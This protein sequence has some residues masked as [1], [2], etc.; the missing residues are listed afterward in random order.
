MAY[1]GKFQ[2]LVSFVAPWFLRQKNLGT[3]LEAVGLLHDGAAD[4]MIQGMRL[5][6]P[7]RCPANQLPTISYDRGI[8]LYPSEPEASQRQRLSMWWQLHKTRGSHQGEM[9]HVQPYFLPGTLPWIRIVHQA[10]DG[11]VATWHTLDPS[12]HYSAT[13]ASPSNWNWDG[14]TSKWSRWWAIVYLPAGYASV[15]TGTWD[16]SSAWDG[17]AL[18]DGL[19]AAIFADLWQMFSDWKAARSWFGGLIV[20]ALQPTDSI[21]GHPGVHPFD[22]ASTSTTNADG[23]TNLP[24]GS[25]GSPVYLSGPSLGLPTRP[26]W[27]TFYNINNG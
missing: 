14:Q 13:T 4:N 1:F 16:G 23:S 7:L 10:G 8:K 18:W 6:Y 17:T 24:T 20:T 3:F 22:P 12:G 5:G 9:R 21:P 19:P 2:R 27:A 15:T 26:S 11:S 25:W